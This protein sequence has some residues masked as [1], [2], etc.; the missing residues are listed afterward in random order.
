[1]PSRPV[2]ACLGK[3]GPRLTTGL[4]RLRDYPPEPYELGLLA[5]SA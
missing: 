3:P 1:M 4:R 2:Q 5:R